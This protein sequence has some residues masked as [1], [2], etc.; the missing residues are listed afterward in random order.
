MFKRITVKPESRLERHVK[1]WINTRGEDYSDNGAE[2]GKE[3]L[4]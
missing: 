1:A 3:G 4:R 2:A